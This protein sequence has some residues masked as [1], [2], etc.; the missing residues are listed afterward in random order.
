MSDISTRLSELKDKI[1]KA[2]QE[3]VRIETRLDELMKR[4][5]SD[6]SCSTLAEARKK[7]K[8]FQAEETKL[9]VELENGVAKLSKEIDER[10]QEVE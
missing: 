9:S 3:K 10:I 8:V 6:H 1:E 2:K 4:L 5:K 7:L